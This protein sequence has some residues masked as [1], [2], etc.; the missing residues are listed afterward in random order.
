MVLGDGRVVKATKDNEHAALWHA[1]PWSH[2]SLGFLVGLTLKIVPIKPY[3]KVRYTAW[4]SMAGY[5]MP[6]CSF[7]A[8][9]RTY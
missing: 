3:V 7:P 1:L 8:T 4:E 6:L 9:R 5:C 2:G